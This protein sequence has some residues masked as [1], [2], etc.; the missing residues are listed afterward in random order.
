MRIPRRFWTGVA[1]LTL[2]APIAAATQKD[3]KDAKES[4]KRPKVTLKA[5]PAISMSPS[6]VVLTAE[7]VGGSNDFEEY[8]CPTVEWEWGDGTTSEV[9]TD[10]DPYLEGKSSIKRRFVVEHIFR[11]G[12][13]RVMFRLK[14]HAKAVAA[15]TATIQVQPGLRDVG[16]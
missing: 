1:C 5:Q 3:D 15:A 12:Q 9:T 14:K 10:C 6:R 8:Y 4:D 16:D 2:A 7:L 13:Y 11:A